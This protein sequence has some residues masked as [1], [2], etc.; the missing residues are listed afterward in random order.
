MLKYQRYMGDVQR[1]AVLGQASP[2]L[3]RYWKALKTG[4]E[5]AYSQI[6]PGK[7]TA[8]LRQIALDTVRKAGIPDFE[9]AFIHGIGLDHVVVPV[10]GSGRLGLFTLET[11]MVINMDLEVHEIGFGGVFFEET[12]LV[13][14][15][16]AE[17][18]YSLPRDLI[19]V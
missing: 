14:E 6:G 18:L 8:E 15:N 19:R 5:A 10:F 11:G 1:T 3:E 13:T 7:S 9:V 2:K 17:R 4:V 16:G 12:M